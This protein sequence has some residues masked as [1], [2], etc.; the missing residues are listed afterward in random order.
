MHDILDAG[1]EVDAGN[2]DVRENLGSEDT[3]KLPTV[4]NSN[5]TSINLNQKDDSVLNKSTYEIRLDS[6]ERTPDTIN[7]T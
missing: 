4:H 1:K 3:T 7:T 2:S 5:A 6:A